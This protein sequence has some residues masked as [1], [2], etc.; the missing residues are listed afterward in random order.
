MGAP[1]GRNRYRRPGRRPAFRDPRPIMLI[2]CEGRNTEPQYFD[3]FAKFHRNSMVRVEIAP[4]H[5]VPLTVVRAA[6]DRR[7]EAINAAKREKDE[8]LKYNSVWCVF[9]MDEH[10][11]VDDA[12]SM[13]RENGI[14]VAISNPCFELWL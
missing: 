9:D 10:P 8:N 1:S 7:N 11:H 13:A 4:D 3:Q 6:K 14:H 12:K 2:V 5:G